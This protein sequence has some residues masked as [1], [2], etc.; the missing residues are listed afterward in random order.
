MT[1][2]V[3]VLQL[4]DSKHICVVLFCVNRQMTYYDLVIYYLHGLFG[5]D[6]NDLCNENMLEFTLK[7]LT[8]LELYISKIENRRYSTSYNKKSITV[9]DICNS[10][11]LACRISSGDCQ[12]REPTIKQYNKV[13]K[14]RIHFNGLDRVIWIGWKGWY[15]GCQIKTFNT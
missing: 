3:N 1:C 7:S 6:C 2:R 8:W 13:K 4:S 11:L 10:K 14:N 9:L 5:F 15:V 12:T